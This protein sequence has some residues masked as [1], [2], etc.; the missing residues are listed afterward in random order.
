M[1]IPF[2][3]TRRPLFENDDR[4]SKL[5]DVEKV[6]GNCRPLTEYDMDES[7]LDR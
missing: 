6:L 1:G 3:Y 2:K 4:S 7:Y 5:Y